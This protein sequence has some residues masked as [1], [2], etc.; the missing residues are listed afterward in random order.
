M[1][2]RIL[3]ILLALVMTASVLL[4]GCANGAADDEEKKDDITDEASETTVSLSM[5]MITEQHVPTEDE[6]KYAEENGTATDKELIEMKATKSAYDRVA[7]ELDKI[8]KAKFRTHLVTS[9]Y[10]ENE[11]KTIV[12][13]MMARKARLANLKSEAKTALAKYRK[14][15]KA[16]G[17]EDEAEIKSLFYSEY[18]EYSPFTEAEVDTN[19]SATEAETVKD[20]YGISQ[21]KYPDIETVELEVTFPGKDTPEKVKVMDQVDIICICGYENYLRYIKNEW[22]HADIESDLDGSSKAIKTYVNEKFLTI[23]GLNENNKIFGVPNNMPIGEY[24]YLLV[25]KELYDE[26]QYDYENVTK[27]ESITEFLKDIKLYRNGENGSEK[28]VP[29]T[30]D[31]GLTNTFFWSLDYEYEKFV[32]VGKVDK[33]DG[34]VKIQKAA[35]LDDDTIYYLR[36]LISGT[37]SDAKYEYR[38]V[39]L[40]PYSNMAYYTAKGTEVQVTA[41]EKGKDYYT[42]DSEGTFVL[43]EPDENG[44]RIPVEGTKYY[45]VTFTA[46]KL[47]VDKNDKEKR[48][49]DDKKEYYTN[50]TVE[51]S[52]VKTDNQYSKVYQFKSGEEYYMIKSATINRDKF[53]V[54]GNV[55]A[56]TAT[57]GTFVTSA[58]MSSQTFKSQLLVIKDIEEN[59]YYDPAALERGDK[60]AAAVVK[61]GANLAAKYGD[62]YHLIPIEYP[63]AQI[64]EVCENMLSVS[65]FTKNLKRSMEVITYINTNAD[66]RNLLQYGVEGENYT[67][68]YKTI[69]SK[70]YPTVQ[71]LNNYY[72]MDIYKT[73]NTFIA[74]PEETMDCRA[75]EYGKLQNADAKY[76]P[77]LGFEINDNINKIDFTT[78]DK[79]KALSES[80]EAR[81]NKCTTQA[82]LNDLLIKITNNLTSTQLYRFETVHG[83][84]QSEGSCADAT[85]AN[86]NPFSVWHA[87]TEWWTPIY[88]VEEE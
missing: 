42:K 27:L 43:V 47:A 3:S 71:R 29:L 18:P 28:F 85:L 72:K 64:E 54:L 21:L 49:F 10:T 51:G 38:M 17:I 32:P 78:V 68:V 87:Y 81:I 75:W 25:H 37:G 45:T 76:D 79:I 6:I 67:V 9:F 82:E 15:Q 26:F 20:K 58:L 35:E 86:Y 41:F 74:Y 69:G 12:E 34:T 55:M 52:T 83:V 56:S 61:G 7:E 30:G 50:Y 62:T 60:F 5:F 24:T 22:L 77:M 80:Y 31:I 1:K 14:E 59:G 53:S 57:Q 19:T 36:K 48:V 65:A 23:A 44:D 70:N 88:Y 73:G 39:S 33:G 66:F 4:V 63:R 13:A 11:Y 16:V 84:L 8:T 2:L 46:E 40:A